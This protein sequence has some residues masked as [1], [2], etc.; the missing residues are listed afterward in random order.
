MT[1]Q[2]AVEV[3]KRIL[4]GWPTQRMRM[5]AS[6]VEGMYVAYVDGLLD[7]EANAVMDAV[8]RCARTSEWMPTIA[9]LRAEAVATVLGA[10]RSGTDAWGEVRALTGYRERPALAG[11]DPLAIR[12]CD[13]FGWLEWR[14]LW[15]GGQDVEQWHIV[16]G[17]NEAAD[18]ARFIDEYNRVVAADRKETAAANGIRRHLTAVPP[19][20]ELD[21]G[22]AVFGGA[23][24]PGDGA[25][26][27]A[28]LRRRLEADA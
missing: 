25:E 1:K 12:I 26:A 6:D 13:Q 15:R 21:A 19:V 23:C 7:L 18:R 17:A 8:R 11:I 5:S 2:Q 24:E 28:E 14:T 4:A 20:A 16:T 3:V 22:A 27:L 10:A 9:K